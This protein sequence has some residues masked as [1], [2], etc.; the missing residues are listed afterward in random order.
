[1]SQDPVIITVDPVDGPCT[2]VAFTDDGTEV[3]GGRVEAVEGRAVFDDLR[4]ALPDGPSQIRRLKFRVQGS[5]LP[6]ALAPE[7]LV[8]Q[9]LMVVEGAVSM[10]FDKATEEVVKSGGMQLQHG[11]PATPPLV[12][13]VARLG[14]GWA[15]VQGCL[16]G[17]GGGK[18][19]ECRG[20]RWWLPWHAVVIPR[21]LVGNFQKAWGTPP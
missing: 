21:E 9:Q 6:E 3:A 2:V 4:L 20:F 17:G 18:G 1:M 8:S 14:L 15:G 12:V 11:A 16:W 7:P 10:R 13:E 19:T 5:D